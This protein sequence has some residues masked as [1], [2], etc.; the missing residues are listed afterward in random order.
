MRAV[1]L[2][3]WPGLLLVL[4]VGC[5]GGAQDLRAGASA[6]AEAVTSTSTS[7]TERPP[8]TT[9]QAPTDPAAEVD[10]GGSKTIA[11]IDYAYPPDRPDVRPPRTPEEALA[12]FRRWR[13]SAAA[14]GDPSAPD[15]GRPRPEKPVPLRYELVDDTPK[16]RPVGEPPRTRFVG[17]D[18]EGAVRAVLH[19]SS[20]PGGG[21][22]IDWY[23]FCDEHWKR[24]GI[25]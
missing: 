8:T 17:R 16:T 25:W 1:P 20:W 6:E 24:G 11:T 14:E 7:T 23:A 18:P 5:A 19:L 21:W 10:C 9:G 15:Y 4:S 2:R 3:A 12:E 22:V 13:N